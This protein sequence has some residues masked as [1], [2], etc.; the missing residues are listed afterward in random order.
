MSQ[1]FFEF[2]VKN[3]NYFNGNHLD[4]SL[5]NI[6]SNPQFSFQQLN[7]IANAWSTNLKKHKQYIELNPNITPEIIE[8]TWDFPWDF[9]QL[10]INP[11]FN[12]DYI[13]SNPEFNWDYKL[14]SSHIPWEIIKEN[15]NLGWNYDLV[16]SNNKS[17]DFETIKYNSNLLSYSNFHFNPNFQFEH[18]FLPYF[19]DIYEFHSGILL[20]KNFKLNEILAYYEYISNKVEKISW[21]SLIHNPN[22]K[23]EDYINYKDLF[24][25]NNGIYGYLS[26]H[27]NITYDIVKNNNTDPWNI[28]YLPQNPNF[29]LNHILSIN[30]LK[31][32]GKEHYNL[33]SYILNI[34]RNPMDEPFRRKTSVNRI[35]NWYSRRLHPK[36]WVPIK[37]SYII[38]NWFESPDC[39]VANKLRI[40]PGF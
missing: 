1:D 20:H 9:S 7:Q 14:L 32:K 21:I 15:P 2:L 6:N 13:S 34:V 3:P 22:L 4:F 38:Q 31:I 37:K 11:N 18:I 5:N 19:N 35:E 28:W 26:C 8:E 36:K 27:P 39:K 12:W 29:L 10:S 23:Y 24:G 30:S 25:F 16:V 40:K 17:I 33:E